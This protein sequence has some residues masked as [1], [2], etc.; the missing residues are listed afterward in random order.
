MSQ[1]LLEKSTNMTPAMKGRATQAIATAWGKSFTARSHFCADVRIKMEEM[2]GGGWSC[3][4]IETG[5]WSFRGCS[6]YII[7]AIGRTRVVLCRVAPASHC[8]SAQ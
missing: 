4:M 2:E 7:I 8:C 6:P 5:G 1:D 3:A